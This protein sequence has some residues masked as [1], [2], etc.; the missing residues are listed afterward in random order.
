[1]KGPSSSSS[2]SS[3]SSSTTTTITTAA[4]ITLSAITSLSLSLSSLDDKH[5]TITK[6]ESKKDTDDL[7]HTYKI[8]CLDG[9]G[10]RG[11]LTTH[12]LTRIVEHDPKFMQN[13]DLICGIIIIINIITIIILIVII[14]IIII[15]I[16]VP[17]PTLL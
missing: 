11:I 1:M 10:V 5:K 4:T 2:Q 8:L 3:S 17:S 13:I 14:A 15:I 16:N 12:L 6:K 9:G 7:R